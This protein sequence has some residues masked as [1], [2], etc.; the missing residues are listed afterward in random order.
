MLTCTPAK[1][2]DLDDIF[3]DSGMDNG[4]LVEAN[5]CL[6]GN[7]NDKEENAM[8][9]SEQETIQCTNAEE[10][11]EVCM[12]K[13]ELRMEAMCDKLRKEFLVKIRTI[14]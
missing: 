14:I 10:C 6:D 1:L 12:H 3:D 2:R 8:G 11:I 4:V 13:S 7:G 9:Q 5:I